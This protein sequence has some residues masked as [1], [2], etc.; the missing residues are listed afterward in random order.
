MSRLFGKAKKAPS[1]ADQ[2][3]KMKETLANMDQREALLNK[4]INDQLVQAKQMMAKKNKNGAL[5]CLKRKKMYE[6]QVQQL[7][8]TRLTLESQLIAIE[9]QSMNV[10]MFRAMQAGK[11]V[12]AE[13][14][15]ELNPDKVQDTMD[16]IQD[17]IADA[18]E[19]GD[20]MSQQIGEPMDE[21]EL[22]GELDDLEALGV[23]EELAGLNV[24]TTV[25]AQGQKVAEPKAAE[26]DELDDLEASLAL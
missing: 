15:K 4:K 12:M 9:N 5:M 18:N 19:I 8:G 22:L 17:Q 3:G 23:D 11:N 13:A 2:I 6:K 16:D 7:N 20:L 26:K 1:A 24:G 10:E 25:P 21:D 14:T